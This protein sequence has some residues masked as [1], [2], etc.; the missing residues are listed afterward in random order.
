V[1]R[2]GW[3]IVQRCPLE[4]LALARSLTS[5][6]Q[7]TQKHSRSVLTYIMNA[8]QT[9]SRAYNYEVHTFAR[10]DCRSFASSLLQMSD[11]PLVREQWR[12]DDYLRDDSRLF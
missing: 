12:R 1:T 5:T 9:N 6:S 10:G 2:G 3:H 4:R 8:T 11:F 7:C